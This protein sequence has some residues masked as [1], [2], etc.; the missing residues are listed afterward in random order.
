MLAWNL[1]EKSSEYHLKLYCNSL[2]YTFLSWHFLRPCPFWIGPIGGPHSTSIFEH[3]ST[4]RWHLV[5]K[6]VWWVGASVIISTSIFEHC[7]TSR[8][9]LV[10]KI[11]WWVGASVIYIVKYSWRHMLLYI[12][13]YNI[14]LMFIYGLHCF[15]SCVWLLI[16]CNEN[17]KR[18]RCRMASRSTLWLF[19]ARTAPG[20]LLWVQRRTESS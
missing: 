17:Q 14:I 1:L 18:R 6:I 2:K 5:F 12:R 9:H 10:F 20:A 7:S 4:S 16:A 8:W 11:V 13:L 19:R 3:C 15:K